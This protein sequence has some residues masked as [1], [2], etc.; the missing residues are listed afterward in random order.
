MNKPH[1][2]ICS[3]IVSA[4]SLA[5]STICM[6]FDYEYLYTQNTRQ[7]SETLDSEK[8]NILQRFFS[9]KTSERCAQY[10]LKRTI[11]QLDQF[12]L[13]EQLTDDKYR[14]MVR[15]LTDKAINEQT[16]KGTSA[17]NESLTVQSATVINPQKESA[18]PLSTVTGFK[19]VGA[20]S[21]NK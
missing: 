5:S 6:S 16:V 9:K 3:I 17:P 21:K 14:Q 15:W 8:Q 2:K 13:D 10:A 20:Q 7:C 12:F 18:E 19:S 11:D 4:I 1:P